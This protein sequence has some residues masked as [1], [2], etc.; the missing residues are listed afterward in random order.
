MMDY[1]DMTKQLL[2]PILKHATLRMAVVALLAVGCGRSAE[3]TRSPAAGGDAPVRLGLVLDDPRA[4]S[5]YTLI[6]PVKST[7]TYLIDMQGRVV[8]LWDSDCTPALGAYLLDNGHLLR[9]GALP[10]VP[11]G[12]GPGA[13]GRIQEFTWD[14]DLVWDFKFNNNTQLPHHDFSRLPNGNVLLIVWD[15][16]TVAEAVAAGRRPDLVDRRS[17]LLDCLVEIKPIGRLTYNTSTTIW[18]ALATRNAGEVLPGAV[19]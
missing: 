8:Q 1:A 5:G 11:G 6:A 2:L 17:F 12:D 14:G 18:G 3:N 15:R 9:S 10:G 7:K 19:F 13:G 4:F 16:K